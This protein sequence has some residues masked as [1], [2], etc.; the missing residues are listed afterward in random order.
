MIQNEYFIAFD[1]KGAPYI[2]HG[3]ADFTHDVVQKHAEIQRQHKYILK[4]INNGKPR[5]FYT[6]AEVDA[7]YGKNKDGASNK[8][9]LGIADRLRQKLEAS[10]KVEAAPATQPAE[11]KAEK[12]TKEKSTKSSSSSSSQ[13]FQAPSSPSLPMNVASMLRRAI[14]TKTKTNRSEEDIA[15][16]FSKLTG[17]DVYTKYASAKAAFEKDPSEANRERLNILHKAWLS[18]QHGRQVRNALVNQN[19]TEDQKEK[20]RQDL[21][22]KYKVRR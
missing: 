17:W 20:I 15:R 4:I 9:R 16:S 7:Y 21:I 1:E 5:Y 18:T 8:A 3:I 14:A 13:S 22:A 11:E 6:Q 12:T 19:S 10:K 2:E